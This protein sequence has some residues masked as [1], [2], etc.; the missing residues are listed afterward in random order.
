VIAVRH[1]PHAQIIAQEA[2]TRVHASG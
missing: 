1:R 2:G